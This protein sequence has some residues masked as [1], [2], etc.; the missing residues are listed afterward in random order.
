MKLFCCIVNKIFTTLKSQT[1]I[2]LAETLVAIAILGVSGAAFATALSTGSIAVN[3]QDAIATAQALAQT[4]LEV[5]QNA[6]YDSSGSSYSSITVP[7]NYTVS[8]AVNTA[9]YG[10]ANIQKI[11][12]SVSHNTSQIYVLQGYKVNR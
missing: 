1:G 3:N 4:Q 5:V 6:V 7:A 9:I 2:A 8:R 10:N 11:T 12:I